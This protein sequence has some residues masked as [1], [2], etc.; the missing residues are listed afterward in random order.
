MDYTKMGVITWKACQEMIHTQENLIER[1]KSLEAEI[2][3]LKKPKAKSKAKA[4]TKT[5]K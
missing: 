4:K 5:E 1:I 3:E 2:K